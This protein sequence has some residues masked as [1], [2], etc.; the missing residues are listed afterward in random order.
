MIP[1]QLQLVGEPVHFQ[2]ASLQVG[3]PLLE[4]FELSSGFEVIVGP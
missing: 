3:G 2:F 1:N 4:L